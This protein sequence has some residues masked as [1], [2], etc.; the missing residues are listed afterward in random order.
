MDITIKTLTPLWTGGVDGK[1][2]RI[3]ETALLGS[4]RWWMEA[5][6]RGM[7]GKVCDPTEQK[8]SV[9]NGLCEVCKIFGAEGQKRRF[10]LEVLEIGISDAIIKHP[11]TAN[12]TYTA[13]GQQKTP[14][15]YFPDLTF[16]LSGCKEPSQLHQDLSSVRSSRVVMPQ[17]AMK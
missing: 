10:R 14:T 1:V 5:L 7:G 13:N 3:H 11:I 16:L 4:L 9:K 2:D 15:W 6:V 8:C 12:R 17:L